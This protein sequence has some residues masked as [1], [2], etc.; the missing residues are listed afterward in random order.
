MGRKKHIAIVGAGAFGA[1]TAYYLAKNKHQVTLID[2]LPPGDNLASSGGQSR[3]IRS[4]YGKDELYVKLVK[5][6]FE[7]WRSFELEW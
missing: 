3:I 6:A 5:E 2:A 7:K 4:V 1:W